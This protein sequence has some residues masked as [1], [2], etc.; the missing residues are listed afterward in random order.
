MTI[1]SYRLNRHLETHVPEEEK[2]FVCELCP[3][4]KKYASERAL[5]KHSEEAHNKIRARRCEYCGV[6]VVRLKKH[7][8]NKHFSESRRKACYFCSKGFVTSDAYVNH[9]LSHTLEK[10]NICR[11]CKKE[12]R[13]ETCLL[14]HL[15]KNHLV[16]DLE[17]GRLDFS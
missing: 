9:M 15:E 11:F 8:A 12:Y 3:N 7:I 4:K 1:N 10:P 6:S 5:K 2:K 14:S 13:L 16:Y 17:E